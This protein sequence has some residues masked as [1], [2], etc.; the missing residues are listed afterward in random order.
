MLKIELRDIEGKEGVFSFKTTKLFSAQKFIQDLTAKHVLSLC[1]THFSEE[2]QDFK[3]AIGY[4]ASMLQTIDFITAYEQGQ[5]TMIDQNVTDNSYVEKPGISCLES[6]VFGKK[7]IMVSG[8]FD[9]RI[10]IVS[11]K[12]LKC[13]MTLKFHTNIVNKIQL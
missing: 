12:T 8:A 7:A 1:T 9:H 3:L 11:L 10:K 5:Y 4:Y 6:L 2:S 13:L